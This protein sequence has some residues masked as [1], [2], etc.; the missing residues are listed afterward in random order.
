MVA[1]A[2]AGGSGGGGSGGAAGGGAG[3]G[4][5]AAGSSC[6]APAG[7]PTSHQ[8]SIVADETWTAAGKSPH[9]VLGTMGVSAKLTI[10]P[11]AEILLDGL[12]GIT[13][14]ANGRLVAEGQP[15]KRIH[16]AAS[17]PSKPFAQL[18]A[19]SGG[20][21]RLAYVDVENGGDPQNS[22]LDTIA[23]LQMQGADQSLPTQPTLFVD[24]VTVKGSRSIGVNLQNGAGFAPGS[25]AL[26]V[27]GAVSYPLALSPRAID[28]VRR[29]AR[30]RAT[31][32]TRSSC[33]AAGATTP[34]RRTARCTNAACRT[35]SGTA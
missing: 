35:A 22:I 26:A 24:H 28:T 4:G 11:C 2:P 6:P 23:T 17:D 14:D 33:P 32:L 5:G 8:G 18:G 27:A 13:V 21:V 16:I 15:D 12:S 30:T 25:Q 19:H 34:S 20:T 7:G 10:E 9:L 1:A 3:T 31:G 29:A